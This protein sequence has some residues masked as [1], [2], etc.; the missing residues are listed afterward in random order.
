[1]QTPD[2][3]T[4]IAS[5]LDHRSLARMSRTSKENAAL[6]KPEVARYHSLKHAAQLIIDERIRTPTDVY[7]AWTIEDDGCMIRYFTNKA[8]GP[9]AL[10]T[11]AVD[12]ASHSIS[13]SSQIGYAIKHP[14]MST[15]FSQLIFFHSVTIQTHCKEDVQ[16]ASIIQQCPIA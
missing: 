16:P 13:V 6:L 10:F 14:N 5:F 11:V 1:M 9:M 4:R 15:V 12:L 8:A 2:I 3:L 7:S